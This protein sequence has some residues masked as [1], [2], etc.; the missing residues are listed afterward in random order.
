M[1]R[2]AGLDIY[3]YA[4]T[5]ILNPI[6]DLVTISPM[7][8]SNCSI[9]RTK[10][11]I[12]KCLKIHS[13][14]NSLKRPVAQCVHPYFN[15]ILFKSSYI[16]VYELYGSNGKS[17]AFSIYK[18]QN[19]YHQLQFYYTKREYRHLYVFYIFV[20]GKRVTAKH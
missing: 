5:K 19:L 18:T 10:I 7:G 3:L 4:M 11:S 9:L 1:G 20:M 17:K 13:N 12:I 14:L 16:Y 6:I 15:S 8:V 2:L